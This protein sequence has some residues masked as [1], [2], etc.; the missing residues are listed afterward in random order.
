M[1][2][3]IKC[4]KQATSRVASTSVLEQSEHKPRSQF[5]MIEMKA[6]F[7]FSLSNKTQFY[8]KYFAVGLEKL[9]CITNYFRFS[10]P[11]PNHIPTCFI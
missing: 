11:F 3:T 10:F 5:E 6:F 8:A 4:L 1:S 7:P 9:A 2:L